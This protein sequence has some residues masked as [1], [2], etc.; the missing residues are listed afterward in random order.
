MMTF[1]SLFG[2]YLIS[3]T[4]PDPQKKGLVK[5]CRKCLALPEIAQLQSDRSISNLMMSH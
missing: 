5:L 4:A 3:L 2:R 1:V